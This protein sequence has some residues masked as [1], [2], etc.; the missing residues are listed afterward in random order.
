MCFSCV[1]KQIDHGNLFTLH[2]IYINFKPLY[3]QGVNVSTPTDA[4]TTGIGGPCPAGFY[5]PQQTEDPI[6]CPNGT[7]RDAIMGTNPTDCLDCKLGQYCGSTNLSDS[8]GPCWPGFYC[9]RGNNVP[10]PTGLS[11]HVLQIQMVSAKKSFNYLGLFLER[12]EWSHWF[13][14][15]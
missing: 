8:T 3:F 12:E 9:Y 15:F 11:P 13:Q 14:V 10:N 2:D 6:A 4:T 7:Y 5:C 1:Y